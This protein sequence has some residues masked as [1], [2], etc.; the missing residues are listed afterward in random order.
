[1]IACLRSA[2]VSKEAYHMAKETYYTH[3]TDPSMIAC[4]RSAQVSIETYAYREKDIFFHMNRSLLTLTYAYLRY[5]S[6]NRP[7][8]PHE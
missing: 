8:L 6:V 3:K 4:L 7:L 1:M 5:A 2:Q